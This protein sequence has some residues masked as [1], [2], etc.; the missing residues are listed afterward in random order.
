M[1]QNDVR[2]CIQSSSPN[3]SIRHQEVIGG[4]KPINKGSSGHVLSAYN[5]L[6]IKDKDDVLKNGYAMTFGERDSE[7]ASIS[8]PIF[9]KKNQIL[10]A[11]TIAGHISNFNK[12][13]CISFLNVL[14]S[15]RVKIEK[16]LI[17]TQ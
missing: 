7:M 16:N 4:K 10:G 2:V 15:S 3:K 5:N 1:G 12:K 14:R 8:V 6:E 13:N 17:Q 9:R 11:L